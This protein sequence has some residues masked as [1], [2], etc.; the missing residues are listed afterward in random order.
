MMRLV[1]FEK[2]ELRPGQRHRVTI[3]VPS[4]ELALWNR[5]MRRVVEPGSFTVMVG[6]SAEDIKLQGK[7]AV[8]EE[9]DGS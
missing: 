1:G 3:A 7:F 5:E 6:A 9:P 4:S 8:V 2:L